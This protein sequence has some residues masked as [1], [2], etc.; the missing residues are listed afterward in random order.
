MPGVE[1]KAVQPASE[2]V[3]GPAKSLSQKMRAVGRSL[4]NV[5]IRDEEFPTTDR[6]LTL[7]GLSRMGVE[8]NPPS[9]IDK[10]S[11]SSSEH[12]RPDVREWICVV[13]SDPKAAR[14]D[15]PAPRP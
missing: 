11:L 6:D 15:E 2:R 12:P 7:S 9:A 1:P 14:T 8:V 5:F 3:V 10:L 13:D 4:L